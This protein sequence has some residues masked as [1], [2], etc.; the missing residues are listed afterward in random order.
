MDPER[1]TPKAIAE[2]LAEFSPK[3]VGLTGSDE[4]VAKA[5]KAYRVYFSSGPKDEDHD[6]IVSK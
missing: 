2:Y 1:D 4:Q 6:Y 3:F 5:T